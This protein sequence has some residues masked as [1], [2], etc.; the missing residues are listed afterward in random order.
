LPGGSAFGH[1]ADSNV[2]VTDSVCFSLVESAHP[3]TST[4]MAPSTAP[5]VR[6]KRL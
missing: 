3:L 6:I 5:T 4:A 2:A 1:G